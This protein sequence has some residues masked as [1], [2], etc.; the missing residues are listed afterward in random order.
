[1]GVAMSEETGSAPWDVLDE[2]LVRIRARRG[3]AEQAGDEGS[4]TRLRAMEAVVQTKLIAVACPDAVVIAGDAARAAYE[5]QSE[6]E[7]YAAAH[8]QRGQSLERCAELNTAVRLLRS[9]NLW[10]WERSPSGQSWRT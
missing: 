10:P 9:A 1:M 8:A 5:G 2:L 3:E 4:A 6:P 7:W